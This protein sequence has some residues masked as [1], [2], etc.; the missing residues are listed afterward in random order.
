L[1]VVEDAEIHDFLGHRGG[2]GGGVFAPDRYQR[3]EA[4]AD[5]ARDATFDGYARAGDSL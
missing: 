3:D 1:I 5:F 4:W 2:G